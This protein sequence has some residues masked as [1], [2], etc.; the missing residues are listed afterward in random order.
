M[1]IATPQGRGSGRAGKGRQSHQDPRNTKRAGAVVLQKGRGVIL[2]QET[3]H[4]RRSKSNDTSQ[5]QHGKE[6]E[7]GRLE[8]SR[9]KDRWQLGSSLLAKGISC[10]AGRKGAKR[11]LPF[12]DRRGKSGSWECLTLGKRTRDAIR[13]GT[14]GLD[15][16]PAC[17]S[18]KRSHQNYRFDD[19]N[20]G[21]KKHKNQDRR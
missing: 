10:W 14:K 9:H 4:F 8:T 16:V 5:V 18:H 11:A 19:L 1:L 3:M 15:K 13:S 17:S 7:R 12:K 2:A 20:A 6:G 21:K